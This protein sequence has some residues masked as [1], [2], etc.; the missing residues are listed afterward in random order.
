MSVV[1][2]SGT[3]R[4]LLLLVAVVGVGV[5]ALLV[6][7]SR[8]RPVQR[9]EKALAILAPQVGLSVIEQGARALAYFRRSYQFR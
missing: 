8:F 6:W 2:I 3:T 9:A 1:P 7:A 5:C 4:L